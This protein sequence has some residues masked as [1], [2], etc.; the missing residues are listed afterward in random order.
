MSFWKVMHKGFLPAVDPPNHNYAH[1]NVAAIEQQ[2]IIDLARLIPHLAKMRCVREE[3]VA[4]LRV[5][6]QTQLYSWIDQQFADFAELHAQ[7][8]IER[9][10]RDYCYFASMYIWA[11]GE[12][13]QK[14]IPREIAVPLN[15][16]AVRLDRK[17]IL[18]YMAYCLTNW[19][20]TNPTRRTASPQ[21]IQSE[22]AYIEA[23][24]DGIRLGNIELVQNFTDEHKRDED[25]FILVHVDIE[26]RAA[27]G[28]KAIIESAAALN[29][30][31]EGMVRVHLEML[32]A[33]LEEMNITLNRMPEK[34]SPDVYF[35]KVRPYI[36]SFEDVVYEGVAPQ[37][38]THRGE[39]GAQSSIVPA[40]Q[41]ALGVQ[42]ND[43][44]LTKHLADMR[45]YMPKEHRQ[46]LA[47]LENRP[48]HISFRHF[49]L[50]HM[51]LKDVYNECV[52]QLFRFRNTHLKY[53]VDY[54][55]KKCDDP[56]GTG[57]TPYVPW[58]TQL[59]KETE[60][61]YL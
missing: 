16:L 20:Q 58:L 17:P 28:I 47:D 35:D 12:T 32:R 4:R 56:K 11:P 42:H 31:N 40:M 21:G 26:A 53:A 61:F 27:K 59:T 23:Y 48:E 2:K 5:I 30:R 37:T 43:S 3:L 50:S 22:E 6:D 25:W 13:P 41:I 15:Y 54:I 19:C 34:C 39:T 33:S 24:V 57:G 29:Q 45:N 36:Y 60:A 49:V 1:I 18:S 14:R 7:S 44:I 38:V 55:Q 52:E 51:A 9:I 46:F 8:D 10:W